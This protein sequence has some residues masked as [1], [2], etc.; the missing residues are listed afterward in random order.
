VVGIGI[1]GTVGTGYKDMLASLQNLQSI[2]AVA[3]DETKPN[4]TP[5]PDKINHIDWE[6]EK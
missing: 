2:N 1:V 5:D 3:S 6:A 4:H